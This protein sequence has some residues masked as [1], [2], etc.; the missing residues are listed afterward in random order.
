MTVRMIHP[1]LPGQTYDAQPSQVP[2]LQETG[3]SEAPDQDEHGEVWP[4]EAQRFG[5]QSSVRIHHPETGGT[6][7]VAASALPYHRERGWQV[8]GEES[9]AEA[10]SLA[11]ATGLPDLADALDAMTVEQL[12]DEARAVGLPVSG[13]KAE[14]VE[15]LRNQPANE[16]AEE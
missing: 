12:R 1:E 9:E 13:T 8:V 6:A 16:E 14:L 15:R 4:V 5:G 11:E 10:V 2:H 3:W 7:V